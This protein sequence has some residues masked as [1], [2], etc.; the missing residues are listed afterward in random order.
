VSH[1]RLTLSKSHVRRPAGEGQSDL[2]CLN[3]QA[4]GLVPEEIAELPRLS[5]P[6]AAVPQCVAVYATVGYGV[7]GVRSATAASVVSSWKVKLSCRYKST[8]VSL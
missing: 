3:R 7:A 1:V 2:W 6:M 5:H 8:P 4:G